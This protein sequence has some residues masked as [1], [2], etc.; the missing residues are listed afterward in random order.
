MLERLARW[1]YRHRWRTL[2]LWIVALV[3][4]LALVNVFGARYAQ[5]FSLPGSESQRAFDVLDERFQARSGDTVDIVFTSEAG[6]T[7][8]AVQQAMEGMF[9]QVLQLP[10]VLGITSPYDE[11]GARQVSQDGTI[12]FA[13]I[14]YDVSADKMTKEQVQQLLDLGEATDAQVPGP[15]DR[16]RRRSDPAGPVRAAWRGA[17]WS[18]WRRRSSSC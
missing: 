7:D 13:T 17:S 16:V 18:A 10:H 14:Q 9:E 3:G 1:S 12:A 15:G 8:P 11:A 5:D 4:F 2:V 6:V